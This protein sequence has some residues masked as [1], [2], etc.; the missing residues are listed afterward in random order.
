MIKINT[1]GWWFMLYLFIVHL[2]KV[3]MLNVA[4]YIRNCTEISKQVTTVRFKIVTEAFLK[5]HVFWDIGC[6]SR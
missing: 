6:V 2:M 4:F 3:S 1:Q 5:I